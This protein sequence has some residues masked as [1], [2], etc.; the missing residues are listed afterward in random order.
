M[1]TSNYRWRADRTLAVALVISI[2]VHLFGAV[3]FERSL[4]VLAH[5]RQHLHM[6]EPQPTPIFV[7][8]SSATTISKKAVP[9]PQ[10]PQHKPQPQQPPP[11]PKQQPQEQSR[12][13][14]VVVPKPQ[15]PPPKIKRE[16]ARVDPHARE[17]EPPTPRP[18]PTANAAAQQAP[19]QKEDTS[20][21]NDEQLAQL[22]QSFQQTIAQARNQQNPLNVPSAAPAAPKRYRVQFQGEFGTLHH[23]EGD[24]WPVQSWLADGYH[25]YY[26][27]YEFVWEDGT[28][29]TGSVPWP[30]HFRPN[31]DPF[32]N[33]ELGRLRRTPLPAPPEGWNLPDGTHVG[34]ALRPL[35]PGKNFQE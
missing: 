12:P 14:V 8:L 28:Y 5:L 15:P 1:I 10:P 34:K 27:A 26:V 22:Q 32:T 4:H 9:V 2:G 33:P 29:E 35:F 17:E 11:Q 18:L 21:L 25:Y 7:T 24:Y 23:G 30:I 13:K 6:P 19:P 20:H 3:L 16:I 31:E